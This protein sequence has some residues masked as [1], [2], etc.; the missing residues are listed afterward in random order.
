MDFVKKEMPADEELFQ[1]LSGSVGSAVTSSAFEELYRRYSK[2]VFRFAFRYVGTREHAE[3]V[4]QEVFLEVHQ[5]KFSPDG[6]GSFRAWIFVV[7]RNKA[8]SLIRRLDFRKQKSEVSLVGATE[9][10]DPSHS[11]E[12]ALIAR[13]FASQFER[14][15]ANLPEDLKKTWGLRKAGADYQ[16]IAEQL[17]IPV[18]T[19]K[20]RFSRLVEYLKKELTLE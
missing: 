13:E 4:L 8:L 3:E 1:L 5:A 10:V 17:G 18:G 6:P 12:E 7:A 2:A 11:F 19:V 16:A 9:P 20:S 15:E 14:A